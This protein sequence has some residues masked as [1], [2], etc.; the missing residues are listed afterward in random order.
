MS[1]FVETRLIASLQGRLIGDKVLK[2][3]DVCKILK[4]ERPETKPFS[5]FII[6][7]S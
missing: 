7:E 1:F 5:F 2:D 4:M 3:T 6:F